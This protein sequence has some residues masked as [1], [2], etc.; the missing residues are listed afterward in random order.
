MLVYHVKYD[1]ARIKTPEEEEEKH[2]SSQIKEQI[3]LEE[4]ESGLESGSDSSSKDG[5]EDD[6]ESGSK[7]VFHVPH[8][9]QLDSSR[10]HWNEPTTREASYISQIFRLDWNFESRGIPV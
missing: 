4:L 9:F 7:E 1:L 10:F 5:S 3:R 6:L 2:R 8:Q